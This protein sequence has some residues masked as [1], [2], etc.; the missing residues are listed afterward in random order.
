VTGRNAVITGGGRGVGA[1]VAAKL[2]SA[3]VAVIVAARTADQIES[4]A[5]ALRVKG[6]AAHAETCDVADPR[7]VERLAA[8]AEKRLGSVDILVNNAGTALASAL[9]KTTLEDWNR[10]FATNATS[11]FLCL[12][13]MMP[14]MIAR[15]WGRVVNVA[16]IA[17]LRGDRYI[18]AYAASKHALVGLTTSA[19]AEAAPHGVTVN[20]VCPGYLRTDMTRESIERIMRTTGRTEEQALDAI[21]QTTPQRRLIEAAE[22]ADAVAYLCSDGAGGVNGA[23]LVIDGGELRR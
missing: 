1:A 2:A 4:V 18:A 9:D 12:K 6:Y 19:A 10:L 16:S 8:R 15:R 23:A 21:L 7:S 5:E 14:G 17:G 22:V 13:A 11:A 3:G 20:A